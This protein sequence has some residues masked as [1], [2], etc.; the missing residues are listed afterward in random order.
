M[1]TESKL[2]RSKDLYEKIIEDD[3]E[4]LIVDVRSKDEHL[5]G[6]VDKAIC[7]PHDNLHDHLEKLPKHKEIILFCRSGNRSAKAFK[8]LSEKGYSNLKDLEGGIVAWN[9]A[10]LPIVKSRK[11]ISL[12]RQVM[13]VAGFL[14]LLGAVLGNFVQYSFWALSAFVGL[15]LFFA[16][17]TG[18]CGMA[19]LLE[20]MPWNKVH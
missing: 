1:Q 3:C 2:I 11:A 8:V 4:S 13:I 6:T 9:E 10:G 20:K 7:I 19:L 5:S 14:I 17:L 15:G 18:F 16:G 12:Q